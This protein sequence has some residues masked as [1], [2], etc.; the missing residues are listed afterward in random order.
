MIIEGNEIY[1]EAGESATVDVSFTVDAGDDVTV[2]SVHML[3]Y[4]A[5]GENMY[6]SDSASIDATNIPAGVY[7][8]QLDAETDAGAGR[9]GPHRLYVLDGKAV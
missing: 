1:L 5:C 7:W 9:I 8:Y 2:S 3:V 4:D 6:E